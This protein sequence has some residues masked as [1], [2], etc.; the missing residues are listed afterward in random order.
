MEGGTT[1]CV[2][3]LPMLLCVALECAGEGMGELPLPRTLPPPLPCATRG[4]PAWSWCE[5]LRSSMRQ[6]SLE[7]APAVSSVAARR[8]HTKSRSGW[9][10]ALGRA[11]R[12]ERVE[13]TACCWSSN[14]LGAAWVAAAACGFCPALTSADGLPVGGRRVVGSL[15]CCGQL[16]LVLVGEPPLPPVPAD[17]HARSCLARRSGFDLPRSVQLAQCTCHEV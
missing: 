7:Q 1:H 6:S 16:Q 9:L 12:A 3:L 14:G 2:R 4:C 8:W 10:R 11:R 15:P 17:F 5:A 13:S